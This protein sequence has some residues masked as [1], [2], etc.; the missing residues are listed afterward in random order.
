MPSNSETSAEKFR[1]RFTLD[2]CLEPMV[3]DE[4]DEEVDLAIVPFIEQEPECGNLDFSYIEFEDIENPDKH[5]N[6]ECTTGE[7]VV[8]EMTSVDNIA[9]K[10]SPD[11][12]QL[13]VT[14]NVTPQSKAPVVPG[15]S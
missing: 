5:I 8:S 11:K 7:T 9:V 10:P 2:D 13:S 4:A 14:I 15:K 12:H 1:H 3:L 6:E